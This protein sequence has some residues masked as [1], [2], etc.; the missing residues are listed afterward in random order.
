MV[1]DE[2]HYPELQRAGPNQDDAWFTLASQLYHIIVIEII[3]IVNR[4]FVN[5]TLSGQCRFAC[6]HLDEGALRREPQ[7]HRFYLFRLT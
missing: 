2:G 7:N 4:I 1:V 6:P 3:R 5:F